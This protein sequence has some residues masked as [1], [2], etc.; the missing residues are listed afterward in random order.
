MRR[1][2]RIVVAPQI[3]LRV[4]RNGLREARRLRWR[5]QERNSVDVVG[6]NRVDACDAGQVF[7]ARHS[8]R[9]ASV[10][11]CG[12][13]TGSADLVKAVDQRKSRAVVYAAEAGADD[14]LVIV[15]KDLPEKS[16][17]GSRGARD[18]D[19]VRPSRLFPPVCNWAR[20]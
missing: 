12:G 7:S 18:R 15:P 20:V 5:L 6:R 2:Q 8:K 3:G 14:G 19:S 17:I 13:E 10:L 9:A 16:G 4:K 1:L 11:D